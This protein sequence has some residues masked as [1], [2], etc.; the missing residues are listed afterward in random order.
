MYRDLQR[1][2]LESMNLQVSSEI[3]DL[4]ECL[5]TGLLGTACQREAKIVPPQDSLLVG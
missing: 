2:T 3:Q 1:E 5:R 4:C